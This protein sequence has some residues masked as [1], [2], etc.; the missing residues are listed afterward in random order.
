M[1]DI[2]IGRGNRFASWGTLCSFT[3]KEVKVS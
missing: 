3:D 2:R 1:F